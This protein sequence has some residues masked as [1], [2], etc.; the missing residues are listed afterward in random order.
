MC[1]DVIHRIRESFN[2]EFVD[3]YEKKQQEMG[4]I[5]EKNKRINKIHQDLHLK[6][7]VVDPELGE[8][9]RPELLLV[10]QDE[11][12]CKEIHC[13]TL[14]CPLTVGDR[15]TRAVAGCPG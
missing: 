10:V 1:Q 9:E 6:S 14:N 13:V 2:K 7:T 4:K 5:K 15:E 8:I 12:V 3:V 11:E